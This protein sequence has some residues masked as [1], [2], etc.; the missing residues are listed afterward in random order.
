MSSPST[1]PAPRESS[2]SRRRS[3]RRSPRSCGATERFHHRRGRRRGGHAVQGSLRPGRGVRHRARHRLADLRGRHHRPRRRRRDDR[4]AAGRRHH[5]RRL[6]HAGHGPAREPGRQDPLHVGRQPERAADAPHDA[7]CDAPL[8]RPALPEPARLGRHIPGL[9]VVC[10][11][12]RDAKGLLKAAIRDDNPVVFF[13]D[14][15][16]YPLGARFRR[17]STSIPLGVADVKRAGDDVTLIATSSMVQSR[18][19]AAELLGARGIAAEVDRPAHHRPLDPEPSSR[20][21]RRPARDRRRRG[22]PELRR[23]RG[24]RRG[25]RG[26]ARSGISTLLWG[27]SVRWTCRSRSRRCSRTRPCLRPRRSRPP[28]AT[29]SPTALQRRPDRERRRCPPR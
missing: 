6:P 13:E 21:R 12:R 27:A 24:V 5:V 14:K 25:H 2:P 4:H 28:L 18:S 26:G 17:A 7:R 19:A 1:A 3:T 16:V 9:K 23:D 10:R 8:G 22:P 11:R 20:R 15:M 29:W